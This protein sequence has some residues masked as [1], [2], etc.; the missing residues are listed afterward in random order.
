M[1]IAEELVGWF[2]PELLPHQDREEVITAGSLLAAR[3]EAVLA[4]HYERGGWCDQCG[5]DWP[6][7]TRRKLDGEEA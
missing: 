1:P 4:L 6:C 7:P 5:D 3:V 2:T